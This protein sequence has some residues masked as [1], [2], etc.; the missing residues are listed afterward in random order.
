MLKL[1]L[2]KSCKEI[3]LIFIMINSTKKMKKHFSILFTRFLDSCIMPHCNFIKPL[4]QSPLQ[5]DIKLDKRITKD[6]RIWSNSLLIT[7]KNIVNNSFLIFFLEVKRADFYSQKFRN[8]D[9]IY[10]IIIG[11]TVPRIR[12][13]IFHKPSNDLMPLLFQEISCNCTI[14]PT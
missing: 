11:R 5:K 3:R 14:N 7:S 10:G 12:N 6:I 13:I 2:I 9:C 1:K 8:F 4:L